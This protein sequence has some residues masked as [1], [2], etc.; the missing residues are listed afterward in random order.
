MFLTQHSLLPL[1]PPLDRLLPHFPRRAL[2]LRL[3]RRRPFR[4][5]SPAPPTAS[6]RGRACGTR[7]P[8]HSA[9][10]LPPG[11]CAE[12]P[13]SPPAL[14]R[15]AI[16]SSCPPASSPPP[17]SGAEAEPALPKAAA[18]GRTKIAVGRACG[19]DER[20]TILGPP[21]RPADDSHGTPPPLGSARSHVVNV[22]TVPQR[23]PL[24]YPGGKT[25]LTPLMRRVLGDLPPDQAWR[26][27]E[28]FAGGG[29]ISLMAVAERRVA[30]SLMVEKDEGVSALWRVIL[31]DSCWLID[32]IRGFAPDAGSVQR[33]LASQDCGDRALA[34]RTLVRNRTSYGGILAAGASGACRGRARTGSPTWPRMARRR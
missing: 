2:H 23:S 9:A 20:A 7:P 17:S 28:P 5:S 30:H 22:S 3:R 34:F 24:R 10:A 12:L 15:P 25:W 33:L 29:S 26:M 21:C 11:A 1:G 19:A 31:C 6:L 27:C 18:R 16:A 8:F 4:P 13:T 14:C 32:R